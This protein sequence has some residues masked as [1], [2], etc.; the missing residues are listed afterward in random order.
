MN[1]GVMYEKAKQPEDAADV[2]IELA[3]EVRRRARPSIAEKAA[4]SAG[5]VYEKVDLLRPRREGVRAR[6]RQVRQGHEG[7][8][9]AVQRRPAAP[10]ARPERRSDRALQ[11]VREDVTPS[12]KTRPTSRS[13]SASSTRTPARKAPRT[14]RSPT[15]RASTARPASASIEAH[16]RAGLMSLQ[17]GQLKRAKDDF[18][19]RAGA[20]EGARTAPSKTA[21]KPWAAQARY[22]E[23][24]L[25]F[26]EYEKVT[27]DVPPAKLE[28]A[29]KQ[30]SKLLAEAEKVYFSV[31]DYQDLKWATAALYP[32]RRRSTTGSP[33][34][35]STRRRRRACPPDQAQAYRDALDAYVVNIQNKAVDA[36]H[37]RLHEGDPDAGLR[38]VHREDSRGAR[39]ARRRQVPAGARVAQQGAHRR[40]PAEP[41]DRARRWRDEDAR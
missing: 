29:L 9:R 3:A 12:A 23:G 17:L 39:P 40:S 21:G 35:S 37:R 33:S 41:R 2:Y 22:N 34:R 10:G 1:A 6:R 38:R 31:V 13:T 24:E 16:T 11:G 26:R 4:F 30:K 18:V 25:I 7:R 36:V 15:T 20:V 28:K 27:L 19:D 5:V 8:R 32:R 14:R